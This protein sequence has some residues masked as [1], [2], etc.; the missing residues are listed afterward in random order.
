MTEPINFGAALRRGWR[1]LIASAVIF[2][3]VAVF[4][5]VSGVSNT[6]P[7]PL[8]WK[9]SATVGAPPSGS[10]S[11][12]GNAVSSA[13][14]L[15]FANS[16]EVKATAVSEAKVAKDS[17]LSVLLT[18]TAAYAT[19]GKAKSTAK[20][21]SNLVVLSASEST[22]NL[23]AAVANAYAKALGEALTAQAAA[24]QAAAS[25]T[26]SQQPASAPSTGYQVLVPALASRAKNTTV[27][28]SNLAASKK[29]RLLAGFLA[30]L[31]IGVLVI[32]IREL[33]DKRLRKPSR[34]EAHFRFPVI[35]EIPASTTTASDPP[36]DPLVM[37]S[38]PASPAAEAY[39][40]LRIAILFEGLAAV[41]PSGGSGFDDFYTT[42]ASPGAFVPSEQYKV[43]EPGTRQIVLVASAGSEATR[44]FVAANLG[45]TFAEAGQRVI[46]I[47]TGDLGS[48]SA[49]T[50]DG[51]FTG[52]ISSADIE[53]HLQ[54]SNLANVSTLSLRPFVR[55]SGAL[56]ARAGVVFDALRP[57][58]D[59]VIVETP[60]LL[61]FP[62]AHALAH[63]V[64]V[65]LVV[66]ESGSTT[67]DEADQAG[68]LLRRLGSP[69]LGV[70][71]TRASVPKREA[72][73][74]S[75]QKH[76][77]AAPDQGNAADTAPET[78]DPPSAETQP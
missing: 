45:A 48:G 54:P 15:F 17:Q 9:A 53:S 36:A 4:V 43:P 40:R 75:R 16:F 74:Q 1:L 31:V 47:N 25:G 71:F 62:H 39:R 42:T 63:A 11:A 73:Q 58:A 61:Q 65:V 10:S 23:A 21:H 34:A 60:P 18:M 14:I 19:N 64:D 32:L 72:R 50:A 37:V 76:Q 59:V 30:G 55:N 8:H 3:V 12:I 67:T 56:V 38:D 24:H 69:V 22:P 57:L 70:V 5:P 20:N 77:A 28:T 51:N 52:A 78:P 49:P 2:A 44:P 41:A 7:K 29:V 46:V 68:D 66:G 33:L 27:H 26:K 35:A 6:K 13:Q